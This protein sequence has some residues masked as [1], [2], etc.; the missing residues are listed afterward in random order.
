[1]DQNEFSRLCRATAHLLH[2]AD[3]D[4]CSRSGILEV[5]GVRAGLFFD[6]L[7][8]PDR[9]VCYM[10][11]GTLPPD[12]RE[13]IAARLLSINLLTGTKTAGVYGLDEKTD[14]VIFVQHFL[15]PDLMTE[16]ELADLLDAYSKH[17]NYLRTTLLDP[18]NHQVLPDLLE[19]SFD[20]SFT[21]LA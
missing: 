7:S 13:D 5:N 21:S 14:T 19:R 11:V 10:D 1:M 6:E 16:V 12:H 8:A 2:A 3:P 4:A 20:T 9:F 15:Y 18:N 17:A